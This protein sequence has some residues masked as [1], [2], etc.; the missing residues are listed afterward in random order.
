ML[1]ELQKH[2]EKWQKHLRAAA[3]KAASTAHLR[4]KYT[5]YEAS[6]RRVVG[7]MKK[8]CV[9]VE[10]ASYKNYGGRGIK[11]LFG[12]VEDGVHWISAN[13][14]R[15]PSPK[16]TLDRTDNDGH[17]VAGNLRWATR[18]EQANNKREYKRQLA[19]E[20]IR[21]L[22]KDGAP[23]V[24]ETLRGF[25]KQGLTDEQ[26]KQRKHSGAGRARSRIRHKELWVTS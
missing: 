14:P 1:R 19:G 6:L 24:Y 7:G 17:Y 4:K 2:P 22:Q 9:N 16:H 15:K 10:D 3:K 26:I 8:R 20:R 21:R 13:L 5:P 25:I 18:A 11:F 23:F 12:S